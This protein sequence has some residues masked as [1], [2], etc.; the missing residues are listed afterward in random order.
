VLGV[1]APALGDELKADL[2]S[3]WHGPTPIEAMVGEDL[4]YDIA[5]LWFDRLAQAR[6]SFSRG[7]RPD[8]YRATLEARTL[9][10]AAWLTR[11]RVQRY[12]S[13]ME[14]GPDGKLRTRSYE[15]Q[16]IK[17]KGG[18]LRDR[19]NFYTFDYRNRQIRYQRARDQEFYK[20]AI[21]PMAEGDPPNDFL[22]TFYNFRAGFY[23]SVT[24]G[25]RYAIPTFSREGTEE[26]VVEILPEEKRPKNQSFFPRD[27]LLSKVILDPEV[28]ETGGGM[29]YVWFDNYGRPARG[30]VE[31]VIGLG[32]VRGRLK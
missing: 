20:E 16:I 29:V 6:L 10:V 31:N 11:D 2:P 4:Y 18:E 28:F 27:G 5:F 13:E 23:G 17:R 3:L 14:V 32:D 30:I 9:G 26:M 15:A 7:E 22:T 1:L 25:A 19:T 12:V 8:T 24:A 21:F